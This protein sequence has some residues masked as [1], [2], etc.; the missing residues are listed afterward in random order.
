VKRPIL[1]FLAAVTLSFGLVGLS[2]ARATTLDS[3]AA[4]AVPAHHDDDHDG[5]KYSHPH[6]HGS[7]HRHHPRHHWDGDDDD[8]DGHDGGHDGHRRRCAGLIVVCLG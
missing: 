8:H 5:Y 6:G 7:G 1:G 4:T 3:T 2:P